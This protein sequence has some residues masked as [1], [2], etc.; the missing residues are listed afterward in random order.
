M[1]P[2]EVDLPSNRPVSGSGSLCLCGEAV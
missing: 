2:R 1:R